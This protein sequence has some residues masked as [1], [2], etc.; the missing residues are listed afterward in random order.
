[1]KETEPDFT[2]ALEKMRHYLLVE[3]IYFYFICVSVL[4]VLTSGYQLHACYSG[5]PEDGG[6][7]PGTGL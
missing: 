4:P 5:N 2:P 6:K 3:N 7:Y 1:M